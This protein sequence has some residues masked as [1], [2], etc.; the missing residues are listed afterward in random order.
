MGVFLAAH[1]HYEV[2]AGEILLRL[3]K[4][5]RMTKVEEIVNPVAVYAHWP[6]SRRLVDGEARMEG[7]GIGIV[8]I[9][10]NITG[11]VVSQRK[12]EGGSVTMSVFGRI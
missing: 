11:I 2:N 4:R 6:I 5:P 9:A 12:R 7:Y 8:G 3:L 1:S 10:K